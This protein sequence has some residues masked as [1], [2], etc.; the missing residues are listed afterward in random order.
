MKFMNMTD[1]H[2]EI[3]S[4][5]DIPAGTGLGSS[6]SFTTALLKALHIHEKRIVPTHE[7]AEQACTV[8]IEK[9]SEPVGKQDQFIAAY[10]G[11]TCFQFLPND[12]VEVTPLKVDSQTL[13]NLEDNLLMFFTG[14]SRSASS[15][16]KDQDERSKKHDSS[17][18]DN[19][20]FTKDLGYKS[21]E[22]LE[23]GDLR[24]FAGLMKIHWE[25]KRQRGGAMSNPDIDRW[26]ELAMANGALGGKVVGAGGGGF[27]MFYSEEKTRLR[28]ALNEAGLREVRFRFD[29]EGTRAVA[30]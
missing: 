26:Y 11:V 12:K 30:Q 17:M 28:Q 29:F 19:L 22:A 7:L 24:A 1:P 21:K 5:A 16:L 6:G 15:I 9:L 27:L 23:A 13:Y 18:I 2:L 10:G 20:H 8:E 14:Y 25:H 4:M 3:T